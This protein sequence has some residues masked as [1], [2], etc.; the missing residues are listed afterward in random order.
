MSKHK[1]TS[2]KLTQ[3]FSNKNKAQLLLQNGTLFKLFCAS[4][5]SIGNDPDSN[6]YPNVK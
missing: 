6:V 4:V 1:V 5:Y 2:K 3:S